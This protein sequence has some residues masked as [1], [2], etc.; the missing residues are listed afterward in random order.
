MQKN[1]TRL[2]YH[3]IKGNTAGVV[4]LTGLTPDEFILLSQ[5]TEKAWQKWMQ[6]ITLEG[7][8]CGRIYKPRNDSMLPA[9]EDRLLFVLSYL[10][11]NPLQE[12]HGAMFGVR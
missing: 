10:K 11:L 1:P 4:A 2:C 3:D 7:K 9:S 8:P 5:S 12:S 6:G